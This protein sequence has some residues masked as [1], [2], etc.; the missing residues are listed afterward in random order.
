MD[1]YA[2]MYKKW[3]NQVK[4]TINIGFPMVSKIIS[5]RHLSIYGHVFMNFNDDKFKLKVWKRFDTSEVMK[6][7]MKKMIMFL[8]FFIANKLVCC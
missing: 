2:Y 1:N 4:K 3:L 5:I 7:I 6:I 8:L